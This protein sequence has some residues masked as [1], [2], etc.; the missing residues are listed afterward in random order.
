MRPWVWLVCGAFAAGA[1]ALSFVWSDRPTGS[2]LAVGVGRT[3]SAATAT[4]V[5][6][7]QAE[8]AKLSQLRAGLNVAKFEEVLGSAYFIRVSKDGA[9]IEKT[10]RGPGGGDP[11]ARP[12][13]W[14]QAEQPP[15]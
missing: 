13:Y 14:V 8:Y 4:P 12:D 15:Q 6:P 1:V 10:F 11:A 2:P 5:D 9:F 3:P 7:R